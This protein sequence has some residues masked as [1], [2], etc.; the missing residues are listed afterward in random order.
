MMSFGETFLV[1]L[2]QFA[3]LLLAGVFAKFAK[4]QTRLK[5]TW[6]ESQFFFFKDKRFL[7]WLQAAACDFT[8]MWL[9]RRSKSQSGCWKHLI[10]SFWE[11]CN[12][13][14][15]TFSHSFG[16]SK[17]CGVKCFLQTKALMKTPLGIWSHFNSKSSH[18]GTVEIFGSTTA[19]MYI[20]DCTWRESA[21]VTDCKHEDFLF[22]YVDDNT[23]VRYS[24]W[25]N[26]CDKLGLLSMCLALN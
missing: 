21:A 26:F 16:L 11:H 15:S 25:T 17:T 19:L 2:Y 18:W 13:S 10:S 14:T 1:Y 8:C 5:D 7:F 20:T 12:Y 6:N 23:A 9:W 3:S 24:Y 22:S 4:K